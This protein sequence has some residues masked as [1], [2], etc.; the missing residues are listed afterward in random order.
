MK[1]I[2]LCLIIVSFAC[3][4]LGYHYEVSQWTQGD[5]DE[6]EICTS[7]VLCPNL[8]DRGGIH[9]R[10]T[11]LPITCSMEQLDSALSFGRKWAIETI[12]CLEWQDSL[13]QSRGV[14]P[15]HGWK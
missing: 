8:G 7:V 9:S 6:I 5:G 10:R 12:K 11:T 3:N 13:V 4:P 15:E 1:A 14:R 2:T